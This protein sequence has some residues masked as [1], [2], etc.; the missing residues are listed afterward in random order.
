[1]E[2]DILRS[3]SSVSVT[4]LDTVS[5]SESCLCSL[6]VCNN[7]CASFSSFIMSAVFVTNIPEPRRLDDLDPWSKRLRNGVRCDTHSMVA[8]WVLDECGF[9]R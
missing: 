7:G 8:F 4:P 2:F 6:R 1:M 5:G 9:S 3:S